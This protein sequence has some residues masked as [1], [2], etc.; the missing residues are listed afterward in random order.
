MIEINF[1]IYVGFKN[2]YF[3]FLF[4]FVASSLNAFY[5]IVMMSIFS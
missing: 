3:V 5:F 1:S 4:F 2:I